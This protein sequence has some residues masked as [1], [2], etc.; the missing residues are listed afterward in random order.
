MG[1]KFKIYLFPF[2]F[3][4]KNQEAFDFFNEQE[5]SNLNAYEH[6]LFKSIDEDQNSLK[7]IEYCYISNHPENK[8]LR[9]LIDSE[10]IQELNSKIT[11]FRNDK[12][13]DQI[14]SIPGEINFYIMNLTGSIKLKLE[15]KK[16]KKND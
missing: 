13:I 7:E 5:D 11:V 16:T 4:K 1:L 2:T 3:F 6:Y 9:I 14:I 12:I 10:E 15:L 8:S